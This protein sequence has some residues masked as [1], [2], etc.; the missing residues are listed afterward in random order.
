MKFK[1]FLHPGWLAALSF[2]KMLYSTFPDF[3]RGKLLDIG[4]GTKPYANDVAVYVT[5]HVGVDHEATLHDKSNVDIFADA[6]NI[7]VADGEFDSVLCTQVLEHLEEPQRAFAEFSRVLKKGGYV[8]ITV[9][10]I[11]HLH[12]QPRDFFRYTKYG[13]NYLSERAGLETVFIKS[14]GGFAMSVMTEIA[15][16]IYYVTKIKL[17]RPL[18]ILLFNICLL[19][20]RCI[21][22]I[23]PTKD[24]LPLGYV[25]VLKKPHN[26][27]QNEI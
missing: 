1:N 22:L 13:L 9:P 11:W 25:V 18:Q 2:N 10:F 6:Y 8:F 7:P 16:S 12:E 4:C 21:D 14:Y 23:D 17:F 27:I 5:E 15:Y 19:F 3:M 24:R 26:Q 20:G